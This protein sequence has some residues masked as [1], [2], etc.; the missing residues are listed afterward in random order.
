MHLHFDEG[1]L[2]N[3]PTQTLMALC[4]ASR[5]GNSHLQFSLNVLERQG[6]LMRLRHMRHLSSRS[7]DTFEFLFDCMDTL[8]DTLYTYSPRQN[9]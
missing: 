7:E 2:T 5:Q 8:M 6:Q 3:H 1:T 9:D 4:S